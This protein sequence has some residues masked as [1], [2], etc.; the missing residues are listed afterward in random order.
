MIPL[1]IHLVTGGDLRF[2]PGIQVTVAS[3]L[4]WMPE[5]RA[6]VFHIL[7]GGLGE[8][9]R[10]GLQGL[11]QRCH[12][13]AELIFHTVPE[14]SLDAFVPG[15]GNSRMYYARIQMASLLADVARVIYLDSDLLLMGDLCELWKSDPDDSVAMACRDRKVL[16]LSEDAP[17]PLAPEEEGLT[18]FNSG[19]MLVDLD[20][21]RAENVE[22]KCLDL[23]SKPCGPY[24]WW[25]QTILNHVIRGKVG[26]L[27]P[28]WNWQSGEVPA[29]GEATPRILH[30]TTG[31]KPWLYWGCSFRFQ[32]W[33]QCYR[34]V[35]GSP[36]RL[37]HENGSWRGLINGLFDA[38]LDRSHLAR[39]LYLAHLKLALKLS[40]K[41]ERT[42][43]IEQK[44]H[45]LTSP[46]KS[47]NHSREKQMLKELQERLSARVG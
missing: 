29:P 19:V 32:A 25:D 21:W 36:V 23:I 39:C 18:Y 31:L 5:D 17:W 24:R 46:R 47:R 26:F 40:E 10:Q 33:R 8:E 28:Q 38:L 9:A 35:A 43:L 20:K 11:V 14:A 41:N 30:Y 37:L 7:D 34:A 6:I 22:Q 42:A 12:S 4:I 13:S 16:R 15:P 1:P 44:I 2:L 45:F 27:P 3:A